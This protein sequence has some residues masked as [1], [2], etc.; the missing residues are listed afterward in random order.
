[1]FS[2]QVLIIINMN[3]VHTLSL[4]RWWRGNR[5]IGILIMTLVSLD[6]IHVNNVR[7]HTHIIYWLLKICM[8]AAA[9]GKFIWIGL[10]MEFSHIVRGV[11]VGV[12]RLDG[13]TTL[14]ARA[15]SADGSLGEGN[16]LR[17]AD[18]QCWVGEELKRAALCLRHRSIL[19]YIYYVQ[20]VF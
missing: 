18:S 19:V 2:H 7:A 10:A 9:R 6:V 5:H 8:R 16:S 17:C 15:G 20:K 12:A 13:K 3:A 14:V 11:E 4:G 1:M